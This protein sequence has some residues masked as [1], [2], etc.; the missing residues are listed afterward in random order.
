MSSELIAV[1]VVPV[2]REKEEFECE[3]PSKSVKLDDPSPPYSEK[4]I[5]TFADLTDQQLR[6]LVK[7]NDEYDEKVLPSLLFV[8]TLRGAKTDEEIV[9]G[10]TRETV[11]EKNGAGQYVSEMTRHRKILYRFW[12]NFVKLFK[13]DLNPR[14]LEDFWQYRAADYLR[15]S[16]ILDAVNF[17]RWG[18]GED[19]TP[20]ETYWQ[21]RPTSYEKL[22]EMLQKLGKRS[23]DEDDKVKEAFETIWAPLVSK[24][25]AEIEAS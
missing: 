8:K 5:P 19:K 20:P 10:Y 1:E 16:E 24:T 14:L 2:V 6:D 25:L 15:Y 21:N 22:S 11:P 23:A 3:H 7:F 13:N 17:K 4:D 9:V 18:L 12:E